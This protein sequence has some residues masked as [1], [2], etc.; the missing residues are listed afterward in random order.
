MYMKTRFKNIYQKVQRLT[1]LTRDLILQG[2]TNRA[3][4]CCIIAQN[5]YT[6]GGV[7]TQNAVA[8][9]FVFSISSLLELQ[10]QNPR[11]WFAAPLYR[12]YIQQINGSS[13]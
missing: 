7:E 5:L 11:H 1:A 3:R 13:V 10:H 4:K 6:Q 12:E 9:L 2:R 8:N